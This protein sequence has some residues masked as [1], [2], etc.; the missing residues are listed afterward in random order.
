M[1]KKAFIKNTIRTTLAGAYE[2]R[3]DLFL[4]SDDIISN[5]SFVD[6]LKNVIPFFSLE[7]SGRATQL[8]RALGIKKPSFS[9]HRPMTSD[10]LHG[11]AGGTVGSALGLV[12]RNPALIRLGASIGSATGLGV[13]GVK[14]TKAIDK[15]KKRYDFS[16]LKPLGLAY[17][18]KRRRQSL[19]ES[20]ALPLSGG[21]RSGMER[22]ERSLKTMTPVK[23]MSDYDMNQIGNL[24]DAGGL[25]PLTSLR[26]IYQNLTT[27]P[28]RK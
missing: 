2:K 4:S 14:R 27:N 10:I 18:A 17:R 26:G 7:R 9:I 19:V 6:K 5:S 3:A 21:F 24:L 23:E 22:A 25:N 20:L 15:V 11:I 12:T 13:S 16:L 1:N 8:A 28:A